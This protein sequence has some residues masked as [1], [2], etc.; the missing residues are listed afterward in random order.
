MKSF[1]THVLWKHRCCHRW[2]YQWHFIV[3]IT[4]GGW[5]MTV[6]LLWNEGRA[7]PW[8]FAHDNGDWFNSWQPCLQSSFEFGTCGGPFAITEPKWYLWETD[9]ETQ[10]LRVMMARMELKFPPTSPTPK[11]DCNN[12]MCACNNDVGYF[13]LVRPMVNGQWSMLYAQVC[14]QWAFY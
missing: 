8:H 9:K 7:V 12:G 4:Q 10:F 11:L 14:T 13:P 3:C 1:M 6:A 2:V 5:R